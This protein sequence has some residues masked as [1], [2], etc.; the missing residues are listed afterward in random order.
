M[1]CSISI[2]GQSRPARRSTGECM[3]YE[4]VYPDRTEQHADRTGQQTDFLGQ[5]GQ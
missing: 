3:L 1:Y 5:Q 2:Q 4:A